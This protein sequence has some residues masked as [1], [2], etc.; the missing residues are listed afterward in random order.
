MLG[1]DEPITAL[2][3]TRGEKLLRLVMSLHLD[4]TLSTR[5]GVAIFY[6]KPVTRV[7]DPIR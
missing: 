2:V 5:F 7:M 3:V 4:R 6:P 1:R